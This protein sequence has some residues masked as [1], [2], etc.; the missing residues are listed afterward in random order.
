MEG[1]EKKR[2]QIIQQLRTVRNDKVVKQKATA[3][4]QR[5]AHLKKKAQETA[6]FAEVE[7]A[8]KKRKFRK[9][10]IMELRKTQKRED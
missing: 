9:E 6:K 4:R 2:H 10:G 5:A 8:K 7:R 1:E 3:A